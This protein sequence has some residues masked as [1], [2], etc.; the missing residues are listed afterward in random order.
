MNRNLL[1]FTVYLFKYVDKRVYKF[2]VSLGIALF[3]LCE[4]IASAH[5]LVVV[6]APRSVAVTQQGGQLL[7]YAVSVHHLRHGSKK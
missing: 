5:K 4:L 3:E 2:V 1:Q 7:E 6:L